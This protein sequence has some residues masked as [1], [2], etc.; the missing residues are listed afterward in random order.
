M[1]IFDYSI[2][3]YLSNIHFG[4]FATRAIAA[5]AD[6]YMFKGLVLIAVLWWLWFQP[7]VRREWRRE[8]VIATF[9]SGTVAF[10]SARLLTHW[11]PFRLRPVYNTELGLHFGDAANRGTA[12]LDW[13]S[14]PSDHAMLWMAVATG[15]LL[16]SPRAGLL[17][18]LYTVL[19]ICAP[20]AYLGLHYPTDLLVGAAM[21][22]AITFF[23]TR[24][25]IRK[26]IA[27][28]TLRWIERYQASSATIAFILCIQLVTQFDELR[29]LA[30]GV[31]DHL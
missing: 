31:F 21:G 1:N 3:A 26:R 13:S 15:I 28:P 16:I 23:M 4:H 29:H 11:L 10:F 9:L 5:F 8:M 24:D 25:A 27:A 30:K 18:L 17:A 2:E 19:F 22:I 20:R 7:D 14:F 12:M 6:F